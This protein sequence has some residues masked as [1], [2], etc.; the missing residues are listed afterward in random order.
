MYEIFL[1]Y[2]KI[3][4]YYDIIISHRDIF[5]GIQNRLIA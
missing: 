4:G 3:L 1:K 2:S 5:N